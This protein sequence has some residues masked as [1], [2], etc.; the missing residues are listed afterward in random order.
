M[1]PL[2][3]PLIAQLVTSFMLQRVEIA[4]NLNPTDLKLLARDLA[5]TSWKVAGPLNNETI[6][7]GPVI[8]CAE[9]M[10]MTKIGQVR[11]RFVLI[12]GSEN[13]YCLG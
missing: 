10:E 2:L 9:H 7:K 1:Q 6:N 13:C 12:D 8:V 5:G 3:S 11:K 4:C